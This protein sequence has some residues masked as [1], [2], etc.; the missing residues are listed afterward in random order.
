MLN[1]MTAYNLRGDRDPRL[2]Q[3][4]QDNFDH[5]SSQI[6]KFIQERD[7]KYTELNRAMKALFVKCMEASISLSNLEIK[8][9]TCIR[10]ELNMPF[11]ESEY[12]NTIEATNSKMEAEFSKFLVRVPDA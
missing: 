2:W 3:A 6:D 9:I 5:H 11:N 8:A 4:L 7:S 12:R 1:E 10:K